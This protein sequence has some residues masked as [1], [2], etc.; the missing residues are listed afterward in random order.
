MKI[1]LISKSDRAGG[2][3]IASHRLFEALKNHGIN[4]SL[5]VQHKRT[6]DPSIHNIANK[7]IVKLLYFFNF[8]IERLILIF[9]L[10]FRKDWFS[11]SIAIT[12]K[13]ISDH[14]LVRSSDIIHIHWVNFG[15][16]SLKD[17][18]K[19]MQ[20]KKP[21]A[22]TLHDM[23]MFTGGCHYNNGC[24]NFLSGCGNC[25]M[26]RFSGTRDLSFKH[27]R[28][29]EKIFINN[30]F[31]LITP[32][33]WFSK[34]VADSAMFKNHNIVTIP[35]TLDSSIFKPRNKAL[36]RKE[37][38]LKND[39]KYLLFGAPNIYDERKGFLLLKKALEKLYYEHTEFA[40]KVE[41]LIFGKTK[42]D[43]ERWLLFPYTVFHYIEDEKMLAQ[44]YNIADITIVPSRQETFGQTASESIAC[45]TPVVAFNTSGQAE[46]I[47]HQ[48]NGYLAKAF[49]IDDLKN[50]ILWLLN[51]NDKDQMQEHIINSFHS[52]YSQSIIV[53]KQ[54]S[55]YRNLL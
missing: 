44:L 37:Y 17:L 6:E 54:I 52:R 25:P 38:K 30:K 15:F 19:L 11:F 55:F 12:G 29:K 40:N 18:H 21:V 14:P 33:S 46:I 13:D 39:K 34:F 4:V 49:N 26:L 43:F 45:G 16:L 28:K 35:N 53:K 23:W 48:K 36:L 5:L 10:K 31:H 47:Q 42:H 7:N 41:I 3:A 9:K 50:G 2:A 27:F 51:N 8:L 20:L 32:T 22:F 24:F 1:C